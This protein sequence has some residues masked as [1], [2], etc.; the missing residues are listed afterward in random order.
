MA[1][2]LNFV[3]Y[4]DQSTQRWTLTDET[5][6]YSATNTGGYGSPNPARNTLALLV[7]AVDRTSGTDTQ[8]SPITFTP[9]TVEDIIFQ[10]DDDSDRYVRAYLFAVPIQT[11]S[12]DTGDYY[13]NSADGLEIVRLKTAGGYDEVALVDLIGVTDVEQQQ[14]DDLCMFYSADVLINTIQYKK[15]IAL[16]STKDCYNPS[17]QE[18]IEDYKN[19]EARFTQAQLALV[20]QHYSYLLQIV[21]AI[22]TWIEQNIDYIDG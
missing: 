12:E 3:P 15:N 9:S 17:L 16:L 13:W 20:N 18:L 6:D 1:L 8:V 2:V 7:Y 5:G 11:G 22:T 19:L 14:I 21:P 10:F 4:K